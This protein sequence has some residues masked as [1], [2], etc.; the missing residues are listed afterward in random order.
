[1]LEEVCGQARAWELEHPD[2]PPLNVKINLSARQLAQADVVAQVADVLSSSGATA[3]RISLEI[4]ESAL[5]FD[6]AGALE[7]LKSLKGLGVSIA[8]DDF[9][10]GNASLTIL[11]ALDV[12]L[13]TI[14]KSFVDGLLVSREDAVIVEHVI[15]LAK[16]LGIVT[17]AEGVETEAQVD[18]LR[19]MTCDLAQGW[20]FSHPQPPDVISRLLAA[21]AGSQEWRPPEG[22]ELDEGEVAAPTVDLTR[23]G[24]G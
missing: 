6:L 21:D 9:G 13:L 20:W 12:D 2:R 7:A 22:D 14:H 4:P 17:V 11:R 19:E 10:T 15:G 16:A 3:D 5:M 1:M 23:F 8:L 18:R 24:G